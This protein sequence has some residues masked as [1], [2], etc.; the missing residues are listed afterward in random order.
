MLFKYRAIDQDGHERDG[1]I[2]SLTRDA[3]IASLQRRGLVI[4]ALEDAEK[5]SILDLEIN[6]FNPI[7]NKDGTLKDFTW[8]FRLDNGTVWDV[9]HVNRKTLL[10][11][12]HPQG[13]KEVVPAKFR[14]TNV[15]SVV[16]KQPAIKV[17][18]VESCDGTEL[19]L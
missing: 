5:K 18:F 4:S 2:E 1:T 10:A 13:T 11:G 3:A 17:E 19:P 14:V 6:I 16:N 8:R 7:K 15:G 9:S 12:L